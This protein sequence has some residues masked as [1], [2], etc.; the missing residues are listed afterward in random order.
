MEHRNGA[1]RSKP[2]RRFGDFAAAGKVTRRPQAAKLPCERNKGGGDAKRRGR[3][4][5]PLK[6]KTKRRSAAALRLSQ[7]EEN[8]YI[9]VVR[10]FFR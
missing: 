5:I 2:R 3:G 10:T 1:P 9:S 8:D 6:N 4:K 7:Y